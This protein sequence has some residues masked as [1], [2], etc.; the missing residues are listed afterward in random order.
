[1][2]FNKSDE[3]NI[4]SFPNPLVLSTVEWHIQMFDFISKTCVI[5]G[6]KYFKELTSYEL[7]LNTLQI[8]TIFNAR[9]LS[10]RVSSRLWYLLPTSEEEFGIINS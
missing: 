4:S 9:K 10:E 7:G 5:L 3:R 1:M 2:T 8:G 6:L